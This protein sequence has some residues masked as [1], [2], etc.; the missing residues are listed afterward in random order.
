MDEV[1]KLSIANFNITYGPD[2]D[3]MLTHFQDILYPAF[4]N[5]QK[6]RTSKNVS[7]FSDVELKLINSEYVLTGNLIRETYYRVRTIVV[8]N[9]LVPSPSSVPTAPY[10]RFIIYL[11]SHRMI[12][13]KNE[14]HSP[15]L[16]SFQAVLRK[17]VDRYTRE[18]NRERDKAGLPQLPNA[19]INIVNMPLPDSIDETINEFAKIKSIN[20]RFFPLNNDIDPGPI[21]ACVRS[22]M[23]SVDSKTGNL[24]FN[25]PKSAK[26][27]SDLFQD[28]I[29]SGVASATVTGEKSDGTKVKITDNQLG[30]ELQIPSAGNL[31]GGDDKRIADYCMKR[32]YLPEAS[33]DNASFYYKALNILELLVNKI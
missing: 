32:N 17:V 15:N 9:E 30:S 31:S 27:I 20:L 2:N 1:K 5:E 24:T 22:A 10:S 18:V 11:K 19:V 13:I 21:L 8:D 3:P 16:K 25:S 29:A 12:L 33:E 6:V 7:Y 23:N 4:C 14:G 26:G 28:S